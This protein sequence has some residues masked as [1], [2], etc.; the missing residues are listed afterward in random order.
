MRKKKVSRHEA[1]HLIG[2]ILAPLIISVI[3][4]KREFDLDIYVALLKKYKTKKPDK[5]WDALDKDLDFL[6]QE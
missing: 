1:V 6:F 3:Q 4:Q 5:I 2:A